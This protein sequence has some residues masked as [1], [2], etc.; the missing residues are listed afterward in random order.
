MED[1]GKEQ[2]SSGKGSRTGTAAGQNGG[3]L[4]R[5]LGVKNLIF[6]EPQASRFAFRF[7]GGEII[8]A[9]PR[10][11][12]AKRQGNYGWLCFTMI[13]KLLRG[14]RDG[15]SCVSL[16]RNGIRITA[17][18]VLQGF[19]C[20]QGVCVTAGRS[21]RYSETAGASHFAAF[22]KDM[23]CC[24]APARQCNGGS[25]TPCVWVTFPLCMSQLCTVDVQ[26]SKQNTW[27]GVL[28]MRQ[29]VIGL[30]CKKTANRRC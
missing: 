12:S 16:Q 8:T 9:G 4:A 19:L 11:A 15:S 3:R 1:D 20:A 10:F 30:S 18:C 24:W 6:P 5:V 23:W 17:G 13:L 29:C 27:N 7:S 25:W 26:D 22:Y 14:V 21:F 28:S 2:R